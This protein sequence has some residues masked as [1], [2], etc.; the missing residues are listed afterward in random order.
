MD[1]SDLATVNAVLNGAA[2]ISLTIG[3]IQIKKGN[4]ALHKKSMLFALGFSI[5]FLISYLVYHANVGSVPYPFH[6]WTRPVY[7]TILIPHVLCAGLMSPFIVIAVRHAFR[8]NFQKHKKLVRW[9]F[10]VWMYV[11]ITGVVIYLMLYRP[12]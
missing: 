4:R 1:I 7:F 2:T 8:E 5:L 12:L 10:P 3:F 9:V 6:D 11:S